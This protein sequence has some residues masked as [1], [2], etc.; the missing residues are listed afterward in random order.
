VHFGLDAVTTA[1][2]LEALADRGAVWSINDG[3]PGT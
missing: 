2:F 3:E 1:A